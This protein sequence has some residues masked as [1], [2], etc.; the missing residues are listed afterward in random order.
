MVNHHIKDIQS[1]L[2]KNS[3]AINNPISAEEISIFFTKCSKIFDD[4]SGFIGVLKQIS[5][6]LNNKDSI[7]WLNYFSQIRCGYF[8]Y[9]KGTEITAFEKKNGIKKVDLEL[10]GNTLC[11]IKSF[12]PTI[13]RS[14]SAVQSEEYVFNNFL[15]KKLIPAFEDQGA[16]LVI[17]DD[18]FSDNSKN[19]RFL[20]YFLSFID[21]P[22]TDRYQIIQNMLGKYLPKIMV[23]SFIQSMV[24]NPSIELLGDKWRELW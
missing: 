22:E 11:E 9:S 20:N 6:D 10:K 1:K 19:F 4:T 2:A 16:E 3:W 12:E 5:Q 21:D 14:E 15:K 13:E 24:E 18:I 17:I 23:V 7:K 8:L